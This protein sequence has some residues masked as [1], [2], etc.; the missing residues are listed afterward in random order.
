MDVFLDSGLRARISRA[1]AGPRRRRRP[2]RAQGEL[3]SSQSPPPRHRIRARSPGIRAPLARRGR[4]RRPHGGPADRAPQSRGAASALRRPGP[5]PD[6][7]PRAEPAVRRRVS[8]FRA[9]RYNRGA[10]A[11]RGYARPPA[12]AARPRRRRLHQGRH[13]GQRAV[14]AAGR[15]A[16]AGSARGRRRS[17]GGVRVDLRRATVVR[18]RGS[19][20][21]RARVRPVR[22]AAGGTG[23]ATRASHSADPTDRSSGPTRSI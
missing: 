2:R 8:G 14:R 6:V 23:S 1:P 7:H 21:A 19:P 16:G 3:G 17:R 4:Q 10:G 12:R 15:L 18:R 22:S 5:W 11:R 13:A 9:L 20:H